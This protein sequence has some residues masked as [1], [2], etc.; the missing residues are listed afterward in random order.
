MKRILFLLIGVA[1]TAMSC[2]TT[3]YSTT[4][5][6][7]YPRTHPRIY[8]GYPN[9][10][11]YSSNHQH[12][13]VNNTNINNTN[14]NNTNINNTNTTINNTTINNSTTDPSKGNVRPNRLP[15]TTTTPPAVNNPTIPNRGDTN[16]TRLNNASNPRNNTPKVEIER[17]TIQQKERLQIN[18]RSKT[19]TT[20]PP[21]NN[22]NRLNNAQKKQ[23]TAPKVQQQAP[24]NKTNKMN[25]K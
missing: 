11:V 15:N 21:K 8:G 18:E 3:G 10:Q 25:P 12:T 16:A 14:I 24:N 23:T 5:T 6:V 20:I 2:G 9:T 19:Q 22:Q 4:S 13:S 17:Q 1:A 7:Y